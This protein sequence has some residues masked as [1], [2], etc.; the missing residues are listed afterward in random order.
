MEFSANSANRRT[1]TMC[2]TTRHL[3]CS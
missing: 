1:T 2:R 3:P